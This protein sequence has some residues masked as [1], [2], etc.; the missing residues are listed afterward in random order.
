MKET[1]FI[2]GEIDSKELKQFLEKGLK[3]IKRS[4]AGVRL[5]F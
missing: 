3:S 4:G 1:K 2:K 5:Y